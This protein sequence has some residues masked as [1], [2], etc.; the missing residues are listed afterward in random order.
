MAKATKKG[1][2]KMNNFPKEKILN[3]DDNSLKELIFEI[4]SLAGG[5]TSKAEKLASDLPSLKNKIS[6]MNSKDF[7]KIMN[8]L[9]KEENKKAEEILRK[10]N[11]Q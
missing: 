2:A 3:L 1:R 7:Q 4:N 8:S 9:D 11:G 5:S 6:K 10:I